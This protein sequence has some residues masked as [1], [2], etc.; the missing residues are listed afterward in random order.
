MEL[1]ARYRNLP[2]DRS[3]LTYPID[4]RAM[5]THSGAMLHPGAERY[6]REHGYL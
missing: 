4:P 1:E 5:C 2:I 3:P 6:Y